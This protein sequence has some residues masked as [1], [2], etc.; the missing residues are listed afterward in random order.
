MTDE[1]IIDWTEGAIRASGRP[2][3]TQ[4]N[5]L[6]ILARHN[7]VPYRDGEDGPRCATCGGPFPCFAVRGMAARYGWTEV[8][9]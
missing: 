3:E 4:F 5:D 1:N 6:A 8:E 2:R 7:W 9:R